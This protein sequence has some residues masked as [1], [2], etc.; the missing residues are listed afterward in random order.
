MDVQTAVGL[1]AQERNM[2]I[3]VIGGGSWGTAL[4]KL[5]ADQGND[6]VMWAY[7]T[8]LEEQINRGHEN[9]MYLPGV[10]LPPNL[11]VTNDLAACVRDKEM[12]V[13]VAPSHV[14]RKVISEAAPHMP[15]GVPIVSAT[16][17]VENETLM[18]VSEILEDVL[19]SHYHPFLCYLSGPSFA[20]EVALNKPTAVTIA[21]YNLRLATRVQE[22]FST[23]LF[24]CYT[25]N[26]VIGVEMGGAIKNVIAI[27]SGAVTS[28]ELGHN[29]TA[30]LITRGLHEITRMAVRMGANPLTLTG[31]AGMGDLVLTCTGGL[32]RNRMVGVK[33]GQGMKLKEVLAEMNMVAEGVKTSQSV[34]NLAQKLGVEMPISEQVY[35]VLYE[36]KDPHQAVHDLMTRTLKPELGAWFG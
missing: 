25:S 22:I 8:E 36:D 4:A 1:H 17:G 10:K 12:I 28:M 6:V 21:S 9:L 18:I 26:D 3:G 30:G 5:L 2:N 15:A 24:R 34:Y 35:K 11:K 31:L 7:E 13:S 29:A 20:R 23:P 32:S 27:A 33:L 19:P 14:V 16:K